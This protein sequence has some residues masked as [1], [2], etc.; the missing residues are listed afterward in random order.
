MEW[1][2][3]MLLGLV[4]GVTEFLPVSSSG[5]LVLVQD[6]MLAADGHLLA[7][8]VFV[9]VGTL[10]A[11]IVYFW[12]DLLV[13]A[14]TLFRKLGR[15]PVN[16][17]DWI[18]L[19]A[20][21]VATVPAVGVGLALGWFIEAYLM[22]PVS[23]AMALIAGSC[24]FIYAEWRQFTHP[25]QRP[26]TIRS[27]FLI[28]CFQVLALIPGFSRSG[29]TLAGGML[30]G[31]SR[32]EAARFSFLLAIPVIAGASAKVTFDFLSEPAVVSLSAVLI[33][34]VTAFIIAVVVIHW[35]LGFVRRHTLW[36]FIWYRFAL[37]ILILYKEFLV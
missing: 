16:E 7:F 21:L 35:F 19:V 11:V 31:L 2:Q 30:L 15:L 29:A 14:Q 5:H 24:L 17:R 27:G 9:H 34:A 3:S 23:V 18:L 8:N 28:G 20:L 33:G 12:R 25:E 37:A 13:L 26:L 1:W 36:P 32:Y 10:L 4:Q 6:V 22:F